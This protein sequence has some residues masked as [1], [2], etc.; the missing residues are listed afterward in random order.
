MPACSS[1][2]AAVCLLWR[3]LHNRHTNAMLVITKNDIATVALWLGH[4]S[5]KSTEVYLHSNMTIKQD[6]IDKIARSTPRPADTSPP[7]SCSRSSKACEPDQP[8]QGSSS[9]SPSTT[10][11]STSSRT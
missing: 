8:A 3:I 2:I 10:G 5:T 1:R 11:G 4:E 9:A 6:A 7:T